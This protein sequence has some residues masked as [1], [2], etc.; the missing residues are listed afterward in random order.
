[1]NESHRLF[2]VLKD[3]K[4]VIFETT[5]KDVKD[6]NK[7]KNTLV[8]ETIAKGFNPSNVRLVSENKIIR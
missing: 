2:G 5:V 6:F 7:L 3:N 4:T 8:S 1:M